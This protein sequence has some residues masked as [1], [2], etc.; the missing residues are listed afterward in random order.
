MHPDTKQVAIHMRQYGLAVL[1]RAAYDLTF[2]EQTRPYAH[3]MAIGHAA[4]GAEIVIK[5]LIAD[6]HPLLIFNQLPRSVNAEDQLT[7]A[8]LFEYR[9]TVQYSELPEL[10]RATTGIR[11]RP[12]KQFLDFGK[13]RNSIIHFAVP[14]TGYQGEALRFLFELMEPFVRHHW[15]ESI[16]GHAA[17]WDE[18][19]WEPEGLRPQLERAGVTIDEGLEFALRKKNYHYNPKRDVMVLNDN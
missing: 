12:L 11:I 15:G 14:N 19:V 16:V 4:H 9:R 17:V 1:G 2:S 3:A 10:L 6:E 13:L 18:Y 8:E 7:I 5:A